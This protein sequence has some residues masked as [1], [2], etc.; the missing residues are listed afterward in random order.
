[1]KRIIL[2]TVLALVV[3]TAVS[4]QPYPTIT[5][6]SPAQ[7]AL[8]ISASA[9]IRI[10]FS[11][12]I[13]SSTLN[14]STVI[15]YGSLTGYHTGSISW[16]ELL[17]RASFDPDIDFARG[18]LVTVTVTT[19]VRIPGGDYMQEPFVWNFIIGVVGG[20]G[21]FGPA[22]PE[23]ES[24]SKPTGIRAADFDG[25]SDIDL[26]TLR[27]SPDQYI[28]TTW[29]ND[30]SGDFTGTN[31]ETDDSYDALD[32]LIPV[33]MDRDGDIDIMMEFLDWSDGQS[34]E[35]TCVDNPFSATIYPAY[36]AGADGFNSGYAVTDFDGD[37]YR[38][39]IQTYFSN[40]GFNSVRVLTYDEYS[41]SFDWA[42]DHTTE[43]KIHN[44]T[45]IA[46]FDN[47][48][49]IDFATTN[50]TDDSIAVWINNG[51]SSFTLSGTFASGRPPTAISA[52]DLNG[53]GYAD[54]VTVN[55]GQDDISVL[56][57][58]GTG[59]FGTPSVFDVDNEPNS[60]V[61]ADLD[62]DGDLDIA[63][64]NPVE[65][66]VTV[67]LNDGHGDF[68]GSRTEFASG[69]STRPPGHITAAD[70]DGDG[71]I[72][73]AT[74][75]G[76][77]YSSYI[78]ILFNIAQPQIVSTLPDQNEL[79]VDP[80]ANISVT[81]N[82]D[83][84]GSTINSS[85]FVVSTRTKGFAAGSISYDN[86]SRTA[87]FN[88]TGDFDA[89]EIVTIS[90]TPDIESADGAPLVSYAWSFT[91]IADAGSARFD[92]D[93]VYGTGVFPR[94]VLAADLNGDGHLDL[95]VANRN[96]HYVSVLLNDGD[97]T[98]AAQV[99]Y[100]VGSYPLYLFAADLDG[101]GDIDLA[102]ANSNDD[103]ISIL[104]NNGS[105]AFP[106]RT[107]YPTANYPSSI[108][109]GDL[110]GDGDIDLITG[111]SGDIA[112]LLNSG[113]GAFPAH[114]DYPTGS[115]ITRAYVFD[116]DDDGDL[117]V[118][119]VQPN[120]DAVVLLANN[121]YGAL[122][123]DQTYATGDQPGYICAADIDDDGD[124]DMIVT[125]RLDDNITIRKNNGNG[126][127]AP[128]P[129]NVAAGT[130]PVEVVAS[131]LDAD[132]DLDLAI[133]NYNTDG[134][135]VL[136]NNGAGSFSYSDFE[137]A[138]DGPYGIFSADLD[139]DGTMDLVVTNLLDVSLSV[140]LNNDIDCVTLPVT[141]TD[142]D[143]PFVA[144]GDTFAILNFASE[145]LDSVTI[146]VHPGQVP[147]Y[148]PA[149]TDWVHRYYEIAPHPPGAT[150]EADVTLYYDQAEFDGSGLVE[151]HALYLYRYD[152]GGHAWEI[153]EGI[154][155]IAVNS[156]RCTGI[157]TFSIWG[158]SD[159]EALVGDEPGQLPVAM[160]LFQNYPNPFNPATQIKYYL[161]RDSDVKLAVY[162]IL[163]R[164]VV[165]LVNGKQEKGYRT[166]TWNGKDHA[167][168]P[169]AS[170][171]YFYKLV[172]GD[173]VQTRKMVLLR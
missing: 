54:L 95:A 14:S 22:N 143:I 145:S 13:E 92:N 128:L 147:P 123:V 74:S 157:T 135:T 162:D 62:D 110:D 171:V 114:D 51:G 55:R 78:Y 19:G 118:A 104:K 39:A 76:G 53:D 67:L 97:G 160:T 113:S 121:G 173:F 163:G 155:N 29:D 124:L 132:G 111:S 2:L 58:D 4:A 129:V 84:N 109:G 33:D 133:A 26:V 64:A 102:V 10:Q 170:G 93:V 150:F 96:S 79:N 69:T 32:D 103:D 30:G 168:R 38:D 165:T 167:G 42:W 105:G 99:T 166:I 142:V 16:L 61:L 115:P 1:M 50:E 83:M 21:T 137:D 12:S 35:L 9:T 91:V 60:L 11:N 7:N 3:S 107:D 156:I 106:S 152:A 24:G 77:Y 100:A 73:L 148:L 116:Y 164:M 25:D 31:S 139:G 98:F 5:A 134:V 119:A 75:N 27:V 141:S 71:D 90:L 80:S 125:N 36:L 57:N 161:S 44:H 47:D 126:T 85:S 154:L 56:L 86:P 138:G 23:L 89:G 82:M 20:S 136:F 72:D 112:V 140:L 40:S 45:C 122:V 49:K 88:P 101:D 169:S 130:G 70:F 34:F 28:I 159:T 46:D 158:F 66:T 68:S 17:K 6:V 87:T 131:D 108:H 52:A 153:N 149:G 18:E 151:E 144:R 81:F 15:V 120:A 59:A 37:G 41:N 172:A 65:Y 8:G 117:D 146:C 63:T 127:F 43:P 94:Y 48:G